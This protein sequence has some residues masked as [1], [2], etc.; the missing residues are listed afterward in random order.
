MKFDLWYF[1]VKKVWKNNDGVNF[2]GVVYS[3]SNP[4]VGLT[5]SWLVEQMLG[6]LNKFSI[7]WKIRNWFMPFWRENM[8]KSRWSWTND[9]V[10]IVERILD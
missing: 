5:N 6:W 10:S 7:S 9:R 3:L 1:V 4:H 8:K 2:N